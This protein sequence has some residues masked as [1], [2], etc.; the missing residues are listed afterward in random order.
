[1]KKRLGWLY[2]KISDPIGGAELC[3]KELAEQVPDDI[4]I[5]DCPPGGIAEDVD[6]YA[7]HNCTQY[8]IDAV[9]KL[10]EKPVIKLVYEQW[11]HGDP[12]LKTWLLNYSNK[13]LFLSQPHVDDFEYPINSPYDLMPTIVNLDRFREA[14]ERRPAFGGR[15]AI[16]IA[17]MTGHHKGIKEAVQWAVRNEERV[18][19]Y[20]GGPPDWRPDNFLDFAPTTDEVYVYD[21][22][23][24][25][26]ALVPWTMS[27]YEKFLFL[28]T[29]LDTCSRTVFEAW[30]SGLELVL[31]D[32]CGAAWWIENRPA[33]I[34]R[35]SD[36]FWSHV[37]E[38]LANGEPRGS[39]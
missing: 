32:K 7:V 3:V 28:P 29:V 12:V 36:M 9:G 8:R 19:F 26:Y 14:R 21:M 15:D 6:A 5:V 25:D 27:L 30:A 38:V 16:W 20:G 34:E 33:D 17:Q 11:W 2:D 31:N 39:A 18:D 23:Q 37:E 1:M 35:G 10:R 13:L 24:I 4:E 22:G